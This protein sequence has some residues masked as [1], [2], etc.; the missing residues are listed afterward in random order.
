MNRGEL[1][2]GTSRRAPVIVVV[3]SL[4]LAVGALALLALLVA[5]A[6][7]Q[8]TYLRARE[9]VDAPN[10]PIPA[11]AAVFPMIFAIFV[12]LAAVVLLGVAL[13][14]LAGRNWTR[15]VTW[16]LGGLALVMACC[17][18]AAAVPSPANEGPAGT[19]WDRVEAAAAQIMPGWVEPVATV[20]GFVVVPALLAPL[21]LLALPP[22]NAFYRPVRLADPAWPRSFAQG[23]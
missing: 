4:A 1:T 19:D 10:V 14:N 7:R 20:S 8:E 6:V 13:A 15:I 11:V 21:I 23:A 22:A 3:S 17:L 18:G 9:D 12:V 5:A 16:S 2:E